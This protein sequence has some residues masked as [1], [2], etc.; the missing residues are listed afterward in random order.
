VSALHG[1][2]M[3]RLWLVS[4]SSWTVCRLRP[5]RFSRPWKSV[6]LRSSSADCRWLRDSSK[7]TLPP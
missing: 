2:L 7:I 6:T 3:M 5:V 1:K 4:S